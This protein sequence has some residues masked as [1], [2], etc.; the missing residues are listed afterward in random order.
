MV[1]VDGT[2]RHWP[3]DLVLLSIGFEGTE[4]TV[5]RSFDIA[6]QQNKIIAND[7]DYRTNKEKYL[8][9]GMREEVKVL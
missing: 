9:L 8:P 3:A 2:E 6:T 7:K 1:V 4:P 5:P